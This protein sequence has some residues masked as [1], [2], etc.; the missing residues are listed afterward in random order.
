MDS[1]HMISAGVRVDG[2]VR[3]TGS[4]HVSGTID[5][6][7]ELDGDVLIEAK[8]STRGPISGR[9]I[10][11]AGTV[12]GDLAASRELEINASGV[13]RGDLVA[14]TLTIHPDAAVTG[15]VTM[16]LDLPSKL[17]GRGSGRSR[18]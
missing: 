11:V 13:V 10:E 9:R 14:S 8:G 6:A 5:G 3:G 12:E 4:L 17:T 15:R 2:T 1:A 18:R 16:R 7:I